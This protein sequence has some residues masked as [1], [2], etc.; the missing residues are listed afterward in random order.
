MVKNYPY[1]GSWLDFEF[2][3]K[4]CLFARIDRRRKLPVTVLLKALGYSVEE[5]LNIFF[6]TNKF[7][8]KN[9]K[10]VL[11]LDLEKLKG[12]M[13]LIDI[14][15]KTGK[16]IVS[17]GIRI[18]RRHIKLMEQSEIKEIILDIFKILAS[19]FGEGEILQLILC[20]KIDF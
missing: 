7:K 6:G 18:N 11:A 20:P 3:P 16:L 4:D 13:S 5:I 14:I 9:D 10:F 19:C 17:Q 15:D 1:R 12:E 2:D 8:F